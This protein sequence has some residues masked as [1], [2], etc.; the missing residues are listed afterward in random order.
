MR[1]DLV[2]AAR[3]SCQAWWDPWIIGELYRTLTVRW[4]FEAERQGRMSEKG[5]RNKVLEQLSLASAEMMRKMGPVMNC[6]DTRSFP[7]NPSW[8]D[9]DTNDEPIL[10]LARAVGAQYI[11]SNNTGDFPPEDE[12]GRHIFDGAEYVTGEQFLSSVRR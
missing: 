7:R 5:S 12:N 10:A 3:L 2:E 1:K 9:A 4:L 8:S 11:V 6:Y